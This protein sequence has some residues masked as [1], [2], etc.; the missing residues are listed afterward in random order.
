MVK[1]INSK[2]KIRVGFDLD[3]VILYNPIRTFRP[4]ASFLKFLKPYL[5]HEKSE[6]FY[7]PNSRL[8]KFIWRQLHKTSFCIADGFKDINQLS[9]KGAI[10]AY[11]ITSRYDF[12]KKD[13]GYWV[14]KLKAR[15]IFK[16]CYY[17][18]S[19][20]QPNT[21][22]QHMIEKLHLDY[23][24]EDNWGIIQK[25]NGSLKK[26]NPVKNGVKVMWISN[27]LDRNIKYQYKFFSL[28]EVADYFNRLF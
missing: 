24:V 17:N 19:N 7:F 16:N 10:D 1:S 28:K 23:F 26:V 15:S 14:K 6:S 5:F 11:L 4:L 18:K 3:G 21:F 12:L 2:R 27:F 22:K 20:M 25:L 8:E 9:K 13:F